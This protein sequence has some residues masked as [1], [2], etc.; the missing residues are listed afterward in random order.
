[1]SSSQTKK[2]SGLLSLIYGLPIGVL[3]GLALEKSKVY[4]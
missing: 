3:L 2:E 1:M 4:P